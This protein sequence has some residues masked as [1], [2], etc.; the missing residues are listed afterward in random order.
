MFDLTELEAGTDWYA[1]PYETFRVELRPATGAVL[2]I[3]RLIPAVYT[4]VMVIE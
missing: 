4:A 3:K 1:H 2:S